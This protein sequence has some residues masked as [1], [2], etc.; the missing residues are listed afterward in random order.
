MPNNVNTQIESSI[1]S[2][3]SEISSLVREAALEAVRDALG[4][5][6][7]PA[8]RGPGR[9][10]GAGRRGP[11]R[12]PKAMAARPGRGGKRVKRSTADVD[13]TAQK[14]LTYV[15]AN[16]G[17]RMDEIATAL[18]TTV[19]SLTLPAQKLLAAK[20]VRTGRRRRGTKYHVGCGAMPKAAAPAKAKRAKKA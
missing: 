19:K 2:F 17:K 18:G 5:G 14:L 16:D 4:D 13:A 1:Q 9:P 12:P 11:G 6:G 7:S 3:V 10:R 15:K 20:A 8:R